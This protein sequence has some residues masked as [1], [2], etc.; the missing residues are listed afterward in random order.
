MTPNVAVNGY[1][2]QAAELLELRPG[3]GEILKINEREVGV[4]LPLRRDDGSLTVVQGYRVQHNG[5]RGPFKGGLRFHAR[6]DLNQSRAFASLMTWKAALLDL[7]FG[8]AHGSLLID[9]SD[10]S[11]AELEALTRQYA[12]AISHIVG[13]DRDV[14]AP[15]LNTDAR[16]MSWF[17]DAYSSRHGYAPG[18]VT[19]KP[20]SL[21]GIPGRDAATGR[22]VVHVLSAAARRWNIDLSAQ[23][24][25]IQGF[26]AVGSWVARELDAR[27]VRVVA[28]SD[29]GGAVLNERGLAVP[30]LVRA[31]EA[32]Y[33]VADAGVAY[34]RIAPAELLTLDCDVLVPAATG[35]AITAL[36]ADLV[37]ASVIVEGAHHPVTPQAD[38]ILADRGVRVVPDIVANGGGLIGSY[39]EWAQNL[40]Q[41]PWDEQR[42]LAELRIRLV[43]AFGQVAEFSE[44]HGCSYRQAAYAVAVE[45]VTDALRLRGRI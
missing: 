16:V 36:N 42:F 35:E 43:G 33:S 20:V 13:P 2:D 31:A 22:G 29:A 28:V 10:F 11:T 4:Q 8:G 5:V 17:L 32:G 38:R 30:A 3:V 24:V 9:P 27:G 12:L 26:G 6:A 44:Q 7:P 37:R 18:V 19:G 25:A 41:Y 40:H 34:E 23:R 15:D 1:I 14:P 39:V 21:G 45:R